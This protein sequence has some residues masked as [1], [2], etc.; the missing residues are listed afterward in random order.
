MS[1]L[2]SSISKI[3]ASSTSF[4]EKAVEFRHFM[5]FSSF[6]LLLD[7]CLVIFFEKALLSSLKSL[8]DPEVNAANAIVFLGVFFFSMALFFPAL[9]QTLRFGIACGYFKWFWSSETKSEYGGGWHYPSLKKDEALKDRDDFVLD[10]ISKHEEE[11]KNKH[12]NL[13]VG[14]ALVLLFAVNFLVIGNESSNTLTQQS[15]LLLDKDFGFWINH[16]INAGVGVFI[17][18]SFVM[19]CLSLNPVEE[20]KVYIPSG[21]GESDV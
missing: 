13:N 15:A 1:D 8:N 4:V 5:L 2:G 19:L 9:R 7:S 3:V 11:I 17:I 16:L 20:D 6:V 12:V 14:F 18:F 21:N 10:I